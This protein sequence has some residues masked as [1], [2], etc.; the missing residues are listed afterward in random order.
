[1]TV[2]LI[3]HGPLSALDGGIPEEFWTG[4]ELDLS[5]LRVFGSE[6]FVHVNKESRKKLD[7]KSNYCTFIG[8]GSNGDYGFCWDLDESKII[9]ISDV[10]WHENKMYR[11]Q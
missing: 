10:V 5:F 6:A 3:N 1:I 4:K 11:D 9:R 7:S 2:Y 8:Y